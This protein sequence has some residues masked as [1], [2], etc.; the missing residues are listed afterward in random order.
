MMMKKVMSMVIVITSMAI[1]QCCSAEDPFSA[2]DYYDQQMPNAS[3]GTGS[4]ATSS[5]SSELT[6]FVVATDLTTAEPT[7]RADAYFPDAEDDLANNE[8]GTEV[9]VVFDGQTATYDAVSGVSITADGA[10][11]TANHGD[12]KG[13]C[14]VVSGTST[15][16]SLTIVGNKKYAMKLNN[17]DL[18]NPDSAAIDLL[19]KKRAYVLLADG[20][21]NRLA[22]GSSSKASDQKGALYCKGK[23]LFNG[24]GQLAV[25]GN[26]NNAIHSAD[27]IVFSPGC[28]IYVQSTANHGIKANDGIIINGGILNV[29]VSAAAAKGI[30]SEADIT[31]NGGRTTVIATG[32]GTYED[33]EAKGAA[34]M[35]C[36]ST[37]TMNGGELLL[38]A[39]GSGGKG[40]KAD[41]EAYINGGTLRVI[42]EGGTYTYSRDSAS[43]KGI[44][45][46]TKNVHG[47]LNI[48]GGDIMVRTSGQGGE[49]IESKGTLAI[50]GE[51]TTVAVAAYDD[52]INSAGDMYLMGGSIT[53]IGTGNDGIDANGNMH[54]SGG[55]I[56]AF[57]AG[58][59]ESGID[60]GEQYKLYITG[61]CVFGIG[62]RID[63]SYA[64][65]T[66]AQPY[67]ATSGSVSA[68]STVTLT[69][70]TTTLATFNMPAYAYQNGTILVSAPGMTSGSS[71]TLDLG[72]QSL[73][74][75]ATTTASSS[76][77]GGMSGGRD[78]GGRPGGW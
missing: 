12:T 13:V 31:I 73:T 58:G 65:T 72:T 39:T 14:Y 57:G 7:T 4:T 22:D 25:Y 37:L 28:N 1:L 44:K 45:V 46:G 41:W 66:G 78:G 60:T 54:I 35:K 6:K 50:D 43:P 3:N 29:E 67:A 23:L 8:F 32:N 30:N 27:Y 9:H 75:N 55:N 77:M 56:V 52:A 64:T 19:S 21:T 18:T 59:A 16:G 68:N 17:V 71:Y 38:K 62:G 69:S 51:G 61:G 33:G 49:G 40:L 20:T 15:A 74:V 42:T 5:G 24:S 36:D 47:V 10:H 76:T 70:G 11:V 63:A 2:S 48:F 26:Y 53:A 34:A